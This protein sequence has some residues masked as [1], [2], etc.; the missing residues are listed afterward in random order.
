[1]RVLFV[2]HTPR[3]SETSVYQNTLQKAAKLRSLRH[4]VSILTA[5]DWAWSRRFSRLNPLIF[6]FLVAVRV[7]REHPRPHVVVFHSYSGWVLNAV[8]RVWRSRPRTI[9]QFHGL[10]PL[11]R[12]RQQRQLKSVGRALSLRY[13][14]VNGVLK[15]RML[16][17]TCRNSDLVV[18]LNSQ[19]VAY[20]REHKW[21][22]ANNIYVLPN[23]VS[24]KFLINR[25]YRREA[26]RLMYLGQWL[27][28][29]GTGY[30][31]EAF[32]CL[33]KADP[34][35]EL[36][37]V[38]T[39]AAEEAVRKDFPGCL[40]NRVFVISRVKTPELVDVFLSSDIFIFPTLS[41][42][43]SVALLEAMATGTPIVTTPVGAAPD[44]L[45]D[46]KSVV[47]V[48]PQDAMALVK[49]IEKLLADP[50]LRETLGRNAQT[51][52]VFY[53]SEKVDE[54]FVSLLSNALAGT[55]P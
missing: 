42:G 51:T 50:Q 49:A 34:S 55:R 27:E 38:G 21:A 26:K 3:D 7:W 40:R 19:E 54:Q 17:S 25:H 22:E 12:L 52:A 8:K 5:D 37:C 13:R 14:I 43:F 9:T 16:A 23:S 15:D 48:P 36:W 10:E 33:A 32:S 44:I 18:C 47:F 30:L 45:T 24:D 53:Q 39:L 2:I 31:A 20:L 35:L 6:P 28:M 29:K 46:G 41:E 11:Y 4:E 1:M